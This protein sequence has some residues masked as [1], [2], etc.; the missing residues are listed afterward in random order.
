MKKVIVIFGF[1]M[2][3][4]ATWFPA[5]VHEVE[6]GV[7]TITATGNSFA[8]LENMKV[9]VDKKAG[10][11]CGEKGFSYRKEHDTAWQQQKDYSTG[12]TTS[13]KQ[14]SITVECNK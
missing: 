11:V 3:G 5:A 2:S 12:M 8:S 14:T 9:K 4:C 6:D 7:Y 1:L 10:V 13:Y